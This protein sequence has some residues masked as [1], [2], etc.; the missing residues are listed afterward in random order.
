MGA[1]QRRLL[2]SMVDRLRRLHRAGAPDDVSVQVAVRSALKIGDA[3][4]N[5]EE[6][7]ALQQEVFAAL[8]NDP[9]T[10][11][12]LPPRTSTQ[13][14][15]KQILDEL[16]SGRISE[17]D[18]QLYA[19]C[20]DSLVLRHE[21]S[22]CPQQFSIAFGGYRTF[23]VSG[24]GCVVLRVTK[25][26]GGDAETGCVLWSPGCLLFGL[27]STGSL[28]EWVTG[29][30]LE[31]GAGTGVAGLS[32]ARRG[33]PVTRVTLT[34]GQPAVVDNLQHNINATGKLQ[35]LAVPT[36]ASMLTWGTMDLSPLEP[37]DVVIGSDLIYDPPSV[38]LLASLLRRLLRPSGNA[39]CAIIAVARRS[40]KNI[41]MLEDALANEG[42]QWRE[43]CFSEES[44][45]EALNWAALA[46][47]FST[48]YPSLRP[49]AVC[50]DSPGQVEALTVVH[51]FP[52]SN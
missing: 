25:F 46:T 4:V 50:K 21:N 7:C 24:S 3:D 48:L 12:Y 16:D 13:K 6:Q 42:L 38:P 32:A 14:L 31:L 52:P 10:Q 39:N 35:A 45:S 17:V 34:D 41:P 22:C 11:A 44:W 15:C 26:I 20:V 30:V 40:E 33:F 19:A 18:D 43:L 51:I 2:K 36:S 5:D 8:F 49:G 1:V 27:I 23:E 37:I 47:D 28:D 29:H 9:V